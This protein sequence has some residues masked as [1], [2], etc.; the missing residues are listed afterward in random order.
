MHVLFVPFNYQNPFQPIAALF[1]HDQAQALRQAGF[2][3]TILSAV[4]VSPGRW[5]GKLAKCKSLGLGYR[6]WQDEGVDVYQ[7]MFPAVPKSPQL[8]QGLRMMAQRFLYRKLRE[9]HQAPD[10]THVQMFPGGDF[11][12]WLYASEGIPYVV[13]EHLS[14]FSQNVYSRWQQQNAR[15]CFQ[16]ASARI[17]VSGHLANTLLEQTRQEFQVI[18]NC[19]DTSLFSTTQT[20]IT[21][22][23]R[24][25]HVGRLD[26]IK[27]QVMLVRAFM[28]ANLPD[29][30]S[31][32]IVGAGE[33]EQNL[34]NV[35][36]ELNAEKRV[37]LYGVAD[38]PT[39][40]KL[41][42]EHHAFVLASRYETD[43]KSVV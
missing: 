10:V 32:T 6:Y 41:L 9:T 38:K 7:Y 22:I 28:A 15:N 33:E 16:H 23:R 42:A 12:Q 35:I 20:S 5:L 18:P 25:I 2:K 30:A 29:D 31:L 3:V 8:T 11:A 14:G 40:V 34:R 27:N 24:F 26:P 13:T 4:A 17:A 43:R 1:F 37:H 21:K 36:A 19:V 39:V